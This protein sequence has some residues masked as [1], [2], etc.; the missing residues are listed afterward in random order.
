[1]TAKDGRTVIYQLVKS[2]TSKDGS[3]K[4]RSGDEVKKYASEHGLTY[5][6]E[7]D[8]FHVYNYVEGTKTYYTAYL[9]KTYDGPMAGVKAEVG[10]LAEAQANYTAI[11]NMSSIFAQNKA[12][13]TLK[14]WT[15]SDYSN[16]YGPVE[17]TN[18]FGAG[19][20]LLADSNAVLNLINP[21]YNG[22]AN[23]AFATYKG[24]INITGGSLVGT[25]RGAHGLYVANGG[26]MYMNAKEGVTPELTKRPDYNDA[27]ITRDKKTQEIKLVNKLGADGSALITVM[28]T[29]T[30]L[31]TD[32][33]GGTL[34]ANQHR[35]QGLRT[36]LG[37][38]LFHRLQR[39]PGLGLQQ[40]LDLPHGRRPGLGFGRLHLLL[41]RHHRRP[42]GDQAA[43]RPEL[44]QDVRGAR[45][46]QLR[47]RLLRQGRA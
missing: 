19:S 16:Y 11:L 43:R 5:G 33:G 10:T 25:A 27:Y 26:V 9:Y 12:E 4:F 39:R 22:G 30:V 29:G 13:L 44:H 18:F 24:K 42:D 45:E 1:M 31:A 32:S 46:E 3:I 15:F 28:S 2:Y 21:D 20:A 14:D 38:R 37:R 6:K 41:Q 7:Y 8:Y 40:L 34:V 36:G 35:R 23:V 47:H 17:G